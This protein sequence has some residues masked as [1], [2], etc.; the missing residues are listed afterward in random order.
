MKAFWAIVRLT[1]RNALRSHIFQLLLAL[2]L[3]AVIVIPTTI[4]GDWTAM[5][6]IQ[7]ALQYSLAAIMFVLALSSVWLSC[8]AMTQDVETYQLHMVVSKP[9]SRVTLWLAKATGVFLLHLVLLILA[10]TV[11]YFAV[12][13]RYNQQDF[14]EQERQ[15]IENEV[16][17]GRRAFYPEPPD[18][19][20][21][22]TEIIRREKEKAEKAG[23]TF[24]ESPLALEQLRQ[25]IRRQLMDQYGEAPYQK[26]KVWEYRNLP[27]DLKMPVFLR[28][29][30]Y[31][32]K[33]DTKDQRFTLGQWIVGVPQLMPEGEKENVFA[34]DQPEAKTQFLMQ[35]MT[36]RPEQIRS[37]E[38][39][40]LALTPDL[41]SPEGTL[42]IAYV[43]HDPEGETQFFQTQD[44]PRLLLP[45]TSFTENY[46][47]SVLVGVLQLLVLIGL[48]CAAAG[49]LSMPMAIFFVASYLLFGM[50]AQV[51]AATDYFSGAAD[52]IGYI[53]GI[54]LMWFIIPMQEFQVTHLVSGGE[55]VE[56]SYI[57]KL[58][59][60]YFVIRALPLILLGI[61][62]YWRR[63]MGLVIRK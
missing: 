18:L 41:I 21:Y 29:R 56:F 20:R 32:A 59:L 12:L 1:N 3:I 6:F 5:G 10:T 62:L 39:H 52:Y 37:G 54:V 45:V 22:V 14:S 27:T 35:P 61:W 34:A 51:M 38:F 43:N 9:V 60:A 63:E 4:S 55:L 26:L 16:L 40:E 24:D 17:V 44:G 15:R 30:A 46:F 49:Q 2:L 28:Y 47:R 36:S 19:D 50:F 25:S 7:I 31:V 13:W 48:S 11:V 57:G 23:Q 58:F 8:F 33:V 42:R 53:V